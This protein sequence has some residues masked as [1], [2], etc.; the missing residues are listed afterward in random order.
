MFLKFNIIYFFRILLL[1]INI[2]YKYTYIYNKG[3]YLKKLP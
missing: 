2:A 3:L 1:T